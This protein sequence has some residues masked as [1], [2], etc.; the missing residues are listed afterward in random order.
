MKFFKFFYAEL[1][2]WIE[3]ILSSI[4]GM[5]GVFVRRNWYYLRF[6]KSKNIYIGVG[7][8]FVRPSQIT[9]S[10]TAS[11][12]ERAYFNADG[13]KIIIADNVAFNVGVNL[14]AAVGG[15]I[16]IGA[17]SLI[18]P[19]VMMRTADHVFSDPNSLIRKQ[20]HSPKDIIIEDNCW[21]GANVIVIGGVRIG[22]GSVIG[23]GSIVTKN[24]PPMSVAVGV[25][26]K[27]IKSRN[28]L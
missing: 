18:G 15:I 27:I 13:G 19:G 3:S 12:V 23:A 16:D 1:F 25:P 9:F 5:T 24:I 20:G 17:N 10:G 11:I 2:S 22:K 14:N 6:A 26:A 8:K 4:P 28:Y 7:C 21:L